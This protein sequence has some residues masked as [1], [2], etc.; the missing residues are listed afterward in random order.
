MKVARTG[1][2]AIVASGS[3][4]AGGLRVTW[5]RDWYLARV[6]WYL[7]SLVS[8]RER[9]RIIDTLRD[10]IDAELTSGSIEQALDGLGNP[11]RLA[12]LYA[13]GIQRRR[14]RWIAGIVASGAALMLYW[15]VFLSY[16]LGMLAVVESS[17]VGE[18]HSSFVF[19]EALAFSG[20][21]GIGIGWS[22]DAA[23]VVPVVLVTA[24]F[25]L[26]SRVWRLFARVPGSPQEL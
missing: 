26:V 5:K 8:G 16:T 13:E 18:S 15:L 12:A 14:P 1:S 19:F 22:G 20:A 6:D 3:T 10:D 9:K 17:G 24:V 4:S 23:L 25:V 2:G 7:D 11:R 21:D